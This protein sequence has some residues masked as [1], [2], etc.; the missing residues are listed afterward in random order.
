MAKKPSKTPKTKSP[1][2]EGDE[3]ATSGFSLAHADGVKTSYS[4]GSP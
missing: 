3:T 1:S 2:F 4:D